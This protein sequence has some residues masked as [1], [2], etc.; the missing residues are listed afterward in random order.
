MHFYGRKHELL[1]DL[2][3]DEECGKE[4]GFRGQNWVYF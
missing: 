4:S 1:I 2:N 3:N